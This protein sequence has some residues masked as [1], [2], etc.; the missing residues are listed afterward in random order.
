MRAQLPGSPALPRAPRTLTLTARGLSRALA[1]GERVFLRR[2]TPG[3]R[4]EFLAAVDASRSLHRGWVEPPA[5]RET[6]AAYVQRSRKLSCDGCVVC[7]LDGGDLVGV[8]NVNEIVR[9]SFLSGYLGYYAFAPSAGRGYLREA[10]F[11]EV[12]RSFERL[13]LHRLEANVQPTNLR[14]RDLVES[15]GFRLEGLSAHYLKV[16][17]RWRDHERWA[18]TV[19]DWRARHPRRATDR[20]REPK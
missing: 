9:G 8:V 17:G 12:R 18:I 13:G 2:P 19:E 20:R 5:T 11:L 10:V 1:I 6:Y 16:G 3:D 14:S 4:S 7:L 15:L